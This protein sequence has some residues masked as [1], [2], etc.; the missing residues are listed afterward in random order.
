M[1]VFERNPS[2]YLRDFGGK[3]MKTSNGQ[4]DKRNRGFNLYFPS[5]SLERKTAQPLVGLIRVE[6]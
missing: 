2:S 6:K 3:P 4:V 1:G 5:A